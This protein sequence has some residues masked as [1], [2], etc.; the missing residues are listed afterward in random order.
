MLTAGVVIIGNG[1]DLGAPEESGMLG[2]PFASAPRVAGRCD[3]ELRPAV[4][5]VFFALDDENNLAA[6]DGREQIRQAIGNNELLRERSPVRAE[7][8]PEPLPRTIQ[9]FPPCAH[10]GGTCAW[11]LPPGRRRV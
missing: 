4:L 9:S 7:C 11:P 3:A 8:V 6:C 1:D 5:D 2:R 10:T